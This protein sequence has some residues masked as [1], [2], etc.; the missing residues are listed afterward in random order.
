[1]FEWISG[2][3]QSGGLP[4]LLFLMFL[5]NV[6]PPIPSELIMPLAGSLARRGEMSFIGAVFTGAMGGMLGSLPLYFAG[7][8]LGEKRM[9]AFADKYGIWLGV[10]GDD[11]KQ[12]DKWFTQHGVKSVFWC[13]IVPGVRALIAIP[14]GI[15]KMPLPLFLGATFAGS[16]VWV[17]ILT[18]A[19][20][21]LG[22]SYKV[23]D[24]ILGPFTYVIVGGILAWMIWRGFQKRKGKKTKR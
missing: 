3:I 14:A 4:G 5:E 16:F 24:K 20:Y 1:M 22:D 9:K 6:F 7:K 21:I 8:T 23:V 19:G 17:L 18:T 2:I 10:D 15:N 11:I 12:A 13:R